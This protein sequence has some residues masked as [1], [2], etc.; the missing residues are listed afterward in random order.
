MPPLASP[1]PPLPPLKALLFDK[2]GTLIDFDRTWG[3]AASA[4]MANLA[5]GSSE[6]LGR[7][8]AVS[9]YVPG[10]QR[11]RPTSPLVA[12]SSAHY[13]PAW[14]EVLGRP[15]T[16]AFFREID[17]LFTQ[18]GA[19]FLT[20]IGDPARLLAELHGAGFGL[21]IV[22]NDGEASARSQAEALGFLHRLG[23]VLGYDSGYGS[24]PD[25]GMI[26]AAA[27]R[28]GHAPEYVAVVG[29]SAHDAEAARGAG[30][31]FILVRSGPAPVDHLVPLADLVLD[32]AD[33]LPLHLALTA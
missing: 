7:L 1:R 2:D 29:D 12:G 14:A 16:P 30:A 27:A 32:R 22:T 3:R 15:A 13:G 23:V 19:R 5:R 26:R 4:V 10:E 11:F 21:G 28:L 31:R 6:A 25:P 8:E 17:A 33:D 18:E 24:K 20:P 9:H